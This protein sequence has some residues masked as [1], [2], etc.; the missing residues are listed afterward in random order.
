M[1]RVDLTLAAQS[2]L[3]EIWEYVATDSLLQADRLL[4]RFSQKFDHLAL[5]PELGRPR[6]EL[7]Q[8]CRS[9]PLGKYCFYFR[10]TEDGILLLRVLH[11]A[12]DIR[13]ISFPAS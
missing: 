7:A 9:F 11:S 5:H 2:D 6:P 4:S 1:P 13:Q 12:R 8:H 3:R 10:P